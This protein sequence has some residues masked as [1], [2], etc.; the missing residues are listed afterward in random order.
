M[1]CISLWREQYWS[2]PTFLVV[3]GRI[4][5]E[6]EKYI[7]TEKENKILPKIL[8]ELGDIKNELKKS[9]A[10]R[11]KRYKEMKQR[12]LTMKMKWKKTH[13]MKKKCC[14]CN[15]KNSLVRCDWKWKYENRKTPSTLKMHGVIFRLIRL[16]GNLLKRSA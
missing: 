9:N 15:W 8:K 10:L 11:D 6:K 13:S 1:L 7:M 3:R 2:K 12:W 5:E 16:I 14:C 4:K